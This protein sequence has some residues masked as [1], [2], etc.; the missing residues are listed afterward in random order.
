MLQTRIDERDTIK[1][2]NELSDTKLK[3]GEQR[4]A[5][6]KKHKAE[7]KAWKKDLGEANKERIKLQNKFSKEVAILVTTTTT[8]PVSAPPSF[9]PEVVCSI[10][11]DP[12]IGYKPK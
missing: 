8:S 4:A 1:V 9:E 7:V 5:I 12:I 2:H 6:L 3:F 11:A 10:C